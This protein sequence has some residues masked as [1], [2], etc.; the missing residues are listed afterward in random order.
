MAIRVALVD[1]HPVVLE[2]LRAALSTVDG[3]EV[4]ATGESVADARRLIV[5][6][7]IDILLLDVRFPDGNGLALLSEHPRNGG[8]AVLILSSFRS[9][10]YV[11]TALRF[12]AKG[13]LLKTTPL[14][15]LIA[16]FA[17]SRRA[18]RRSPRTWFARGA[19]RSST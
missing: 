19:T 7:D 4:V 10:Q 6:R 12:G 18:A 3:I 16:Q 2:G 15:E 13:F 11:A 8:P 17:R 5:R 1:D 14:P 9:R